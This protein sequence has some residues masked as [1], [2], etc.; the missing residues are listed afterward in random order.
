MSENNKNKNALIILM[1]NPKKGHVK[2][3]L[4]EHIGQDKAL[5]VYLFLIDHVK[6]IT[7]NLEICSKLLFY[8][9]F[10]D[11]NDDWDNKI[12][13]KGIQEG[14]D[15]GD[16]IMNVFEKTLKKYKKAVLIVTDCYDLTSEIIKKAFKELNKN[17]VVIGP[18][19][20]GGYYL[21]GMKKLHSKLFEDKRWS[22]DTVCSDTLNDIKNLDLSY[23]LLEYLS[24]ID[25]I[26]DLIK[27][28]LSKMLDIKKSLSIDLKRL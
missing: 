17:D 26:E 13:E 11:K 8:S 9:S 22:T 2:T 28:P 20:D 24:D 23:S 15:L 12:Y 19:T 6:Q 3:R 21:I 27:S 4:A 16:R 14:D 5:E 7:Q 10:I 18:D 25:T 1:K